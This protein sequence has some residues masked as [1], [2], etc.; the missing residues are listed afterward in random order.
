MEYAL[1]VDLH[2]IETLVLQLED[3][4]QILTTGV[5]NS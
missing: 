4:S 1:H 5:S 2:I 3:S